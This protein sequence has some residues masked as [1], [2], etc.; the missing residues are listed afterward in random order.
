MLAVGNIGNL[1]YGEFAFADVD[2][3]AGLLIFC[4]VGF[5]RLERKQFFTKNFP[6]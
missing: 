4:A 2:R 3:I 6:A 1:T 5:H